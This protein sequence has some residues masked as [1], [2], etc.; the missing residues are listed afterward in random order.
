MRL[1]S[2]DMHLKNF[3]IINQNGKIEI[4]PCYDLLNTTIE[5]KKASEEIALTLK[6][7]KNKL[8]KR[9]LIEYFGGEK[10]ELSD[11]VIAK[12]VAAI[13]N[14]KPDWIEEIHNSF[15][16]DEM[17]EKYIDLVESRFE[18]LGI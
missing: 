11:K 9:M 1:E 6:G 10:C 4:S 13:V 7:E 5:L 2:P 16:S 12:T 17:K 14:A 3:S 18:R 8:T 15:L